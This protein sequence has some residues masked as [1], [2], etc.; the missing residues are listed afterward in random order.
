VT[1]TQG[2]VGFGA[3]GF[4][5]VCRELGIDQSDGATVLIRLSAINT[6]DVMRNGDAILSWGQEGA[7]MI[8]GFLA[9]GDW[10]VLERR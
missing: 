4:A 8:G 9:G 3:K 5:G 6:V 7:D 1:R 2:E 10:R